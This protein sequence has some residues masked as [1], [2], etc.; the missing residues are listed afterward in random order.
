[1]KVTCSCGFDV[2]VGRF[3]D[4]ADFSEAVLRVAAHPSHP[5]DDMAGMV[6]IECDLGHTHKTG[7]DENI[8]PIA[9]ATRDSEW[10]RK[11]MLCRRTA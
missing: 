8:N 7:P 2:E 11:H 1:M 6:E 4:I 3:S 5:G 9:R 10:M